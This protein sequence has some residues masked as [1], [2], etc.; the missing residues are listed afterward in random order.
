MPEAR[1]YMTDAAAD[2]LVAGGLDR[3]FEVEHDLP[4]GINEV[5]LSGLFAR[6]LDHALHARPDLAPDGWSVDPEYNRL[7]ENDPKLIPTFRGQLA[8]LARELGWPVEAFVGSAT[9]KLIPD[10]I[11]HRRKSGRLN[12][13]LIVCE[14]KRIDASKQAIAAD[15]V[16]LA[17]YR[18]YLEYEH[19]FLI[20]LSD[21]REEC[22]V[23]RASTSLQEIAWYVRHLE[24]AAAIRR[25]KR[26]YEKA[27][28]RQ[29]ELL[30]AE[31]AQPAL[32]VAE[33]LSAL[34]ALETM[35]MWPASRDA[36]S[37]QGIQQVRRRWARV[38]HRA[39][40]ARTR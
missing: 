14:L 12:G 36:I 11:V 30:A 32:A 5:T 17:E 24:E 7:G 38:Q 2:A 1:P 21:T 3:L 35:G 27:T 10:V 25:R 22:V 20:L 23:H 34:N 33:S 18:N 29:H 31:G 9:G 26:G 15:L 28:Q 39:K 19:A 6:H 13:N 8:S 4:S 16:K 37:E 40:Q